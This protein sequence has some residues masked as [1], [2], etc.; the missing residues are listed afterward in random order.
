MNRDV[1]AIAPRGASSD[2]SNPAF[3]SDRGMRAVPYQR[4]A[5]ATIS[6]L[7]FIVKRKP[8]PPAAMRR[9]RK[10][11]ICRGRAVRAA[12]LSLDAPLGRRN[13]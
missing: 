4:V 1:K 2:T 8:F 11:C 6:A 13:A 3:A 5:V 10:P 7:R 9:Q 12:S